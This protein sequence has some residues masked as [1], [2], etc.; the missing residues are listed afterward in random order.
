[1]S[2]SA[3]GQNQN[4]KATPE[5]AGGRRDDGLGTGINLTPGIDCSA[6]IRFTDE[7]RNGECG[8]NGGVGGWEPGVG[9]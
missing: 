2:P 4:I 3:L 7:V 1:M 8:H 5:L 9:G 6:D